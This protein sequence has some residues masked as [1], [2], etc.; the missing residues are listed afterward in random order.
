MRY[1][2]T[3]SF[4]VASSSKRGRFLAAVVKTGRQGI[5]KNAKKNNTFH[6]LGH[7]MLKATVCLFVGSWHQSTLK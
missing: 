7:L 3:N 4:S 2:F 1:G 6:F 5:D